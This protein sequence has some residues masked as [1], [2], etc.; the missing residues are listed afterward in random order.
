MTGVTTALTLEQS[1]WCLGKNAPRVIEG[2]GWLCRKARELFGCFQRL[3][4][5]SWVPPVL[6]SQPIPGLSVEQCLCVVPERVFPE[7][8][9]PLEGQ[10]AKGPGW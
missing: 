10:S 4:K 8:F 6:K 5:G 1:P 7:A 2:K 3:P 9:S